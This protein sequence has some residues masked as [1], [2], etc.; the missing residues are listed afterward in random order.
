MAP[1]LRATD[2]IHGDALLNR[3]DRPDVT[4]PISVSTTFRVN[5]DPDAPGYQDDDPRNPSRHVY[6]RYTQDISTRA[7][8]VLSKINDGYAMTFASGLAA[9]YAVMVQYKPKRLA[10]TGGYWGIYQTVQAYSKAKDEEVKVIDLDAEYEPGDVV[11][12]ETPVNPTGECRDIAYYAEKIHKVGGKLI[13]DSTLAPPPLQYPFEFGADCVIHSGTKYFGGHCDLLCG[14]VIVKTEAE[15]K[16]LLH[17]RTYMGTMIG[18]LEAWLL[19]RSLRTLHL[20]IARQSENATKLVEWFKLVIENTASGQDYD[21]VPAGLL[22]KVLHS[23]VQGVDKRGFDP[24]SQLKNGWNATFSIHLSDVVYAKNLPCCTQYF[25]PATS[26]GG[27]E[28]IIGWRA[29]VAPGENPLLVQL[30]VGCEDFD[31]LKDDLRDA[32]KKVVE[33]GK[34]AK[35]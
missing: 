30:S 24:K 21:G 22:T 10:I 5:P 33:I 20:R 35:D 18:S 31:E 4:P 17:D 15:W 19:L 16:T 8:H 23:S 7:E 2:L 1:K 12:L 14:V 32:F 11:W 28:S 3:D 34:K 27:V 6:S 26:F 9:S 25:L 13:V 29:R